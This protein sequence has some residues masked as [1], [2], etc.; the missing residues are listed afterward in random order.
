MNG[1]KMANLMLTPS[2]HTL[3]R[4]ITDILEG[5]G[6]VIVHSNGEVFLESDPYDFKMTFSLTTFAKDLAKRLEQAS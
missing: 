4:E 5:H 6:F 2:W 3:E 1:E